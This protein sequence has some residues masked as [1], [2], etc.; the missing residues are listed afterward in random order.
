[1]NNFATDEVYNLYESE[2]RQ[3]I[4]I[5]S[6]QKITSNLE[7]IRN[8]QYVLYTELSRTNE[9]LGDVSGSI[10]EALQSINSIEMIGENL[11]ASMSHIVSNSYITSYCSQIT[12]RNTQISAMVDLWG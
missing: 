8:N 6:L 7:A 11:E 12:A 9:I 4:V 2:L 5:N 3:N 1:M 10:N